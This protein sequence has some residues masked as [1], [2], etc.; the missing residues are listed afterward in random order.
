MIVN[1]PDPGNR[2]S[3]GPDPAPDR[4]T[5]PP[6]TTSWTID[7]VTATGSTNTDLIAAAGRGAPHGTVLVA[8][9]QTGGKGR[10]GRSWIAPPGSALMF[11]VLL[12]PEPVPPA[13][14]GWLGLMF[15]VA[16]ARG[17]AATTPLQPRLK[18]P[19]DVLVDGSKTAGIL[20]EAADGA[21][22]V[23]AGINLT[24]NRQDL[25]R[26]DATSLVLA[27]ADP[28]DLECDRLLDAILAALDPMLTGWSAAGGDAESSGVAAAYRSLCD[29]LGSA[30]AIELPGGSRASGRAIGIGE[31]GAIVIDVDD[32][33]PGPRTF[34]AGD[35]HHLR[36]RTA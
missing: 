18:W 4:K 36:P 1:P 6:G 17:I 7:H 11:S 8:D 10:R 2:A 5:A 9:E 27:G 3:A 26:P 29:T 35:V 13:R 31:D 23:G 15:G 14:W 30:V 21:V 25:P 16:I 12:R 28:A 22:V 33:G 32:D 19:N 20:A 24:Q 34:H